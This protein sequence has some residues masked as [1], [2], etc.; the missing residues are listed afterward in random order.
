MS[1]LKS[2]QAHEIGTP[3]EAS[4]TAQVSAKEAEVE[5]ARAVTA[6]AE[7]KLAALEQEFQSSGA[8]AEWTQPDDSGAN[9]P[10]P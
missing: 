5:S 3:G 1:L 7:K 4:I 9:S 6:E 8:P 2:Q 10:P